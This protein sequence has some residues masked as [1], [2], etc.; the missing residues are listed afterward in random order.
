MIGHPQNDGCWCVLPIPLQYFSENSWSR[1]HSMHLFCCRNNCYS[2]C[3]WSYKY[4]FVNINLSL[5]DRI[6]CVSNWIIGGIRLV[7]RAVHSN[8]SQ[9][10]TQNHHGELQSR[11]CIH[12]L[13]HVWS[14]VLRWNFVWGEQIDVKYKKL[15]VLLTERLFS[16]FHSV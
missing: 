13:R 12:G 8:T 10:G 4:T 7:R 1:K 2:D 14:S 9:A 11:N 6:G 3:E 15:R 16:G 5:H